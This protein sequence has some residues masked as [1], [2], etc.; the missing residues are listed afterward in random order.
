[1]NVLVG[2]FNNDNWDDIYVSNDFHDN[3]Y[4]YLNNKDGSF[5]E[6]NKKAFGHE[7]R[8]SMGSDGADLNNDGWL[9][10]V[11]MD[12]LPRDEKVLKS[13]AGDDPFEIYQYKMSYG[14][15]NQ[16]SRNCLQLNVG[17]GKYFSEIGLYS[18]IAAT[19]WSWAPLAAD[20]DNDGI[21]DLFISNGI[22]KR[23]NDLDYVKFVSSP[24]MLQ[25]LEKGKTSDIIAI[26]KMPSGK[27]ANC[28]FQG[29]PD[30]KFIDRS[31]DWG[32][33][34]PTLSNGVAYADLDNDGD[35]DLIINNINSPAMMYKNNSRER[36]KQSFLDIELKGI[37]YNTNAYGAKVVIKNKGMLQLNYLTGSRGFLSSSTKIVHFGLGK[38]KNIDTLQVIWPSGKMQ[39]LTNVKVNQ[40]LTLKEEN[41]SLLVKLCLPTD[42]VKR[43]VLFYKDVTKEKGIYWKHQER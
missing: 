8:F 17:G 27:V 32:F 6:T 2:D 38:E 5:S 31:K 11:T 9:D 25:S 43:E 21:K 19:D 3:D 42:S 34:E 39:L 22:V 15:H 41:A 26:D 24:A 40:R 28:M 30:I 13:S 10:I 23:P 35:L 20:F 16:Y 36:N 37:G 12:M 7:S 33:D 1:M 14:Y 4:Y 18:G 29:Q